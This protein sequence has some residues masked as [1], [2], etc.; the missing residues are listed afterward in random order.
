ILVGGISGFGV[1]GGAHRLW[2]H[3]SY[4]AKLPLRIILI[5]SFSASGQNPLFDWVRDHRVHHKYSETDADPHNAN[6]GFFF[7][8]VGWLMMKKHPEVIR[9][10]KMIFMEDILSDPVVIFHQKYFWPM[11]MILC[12]ILPT[13]I[14]I[15]LWNESWTNSILSMCFVRVCCGLNFTWLVN[16]AAHIWGNRPYDKRIMPAENPTVSFLAMG[17]GWHNYHHVFPWDYKAGELGNYSGYTLNITTLLIDLF[18][19][20]GWAYDMKSPD[21]EFIRKILLRSKLHPAKDILAPVAHYL[22]TKT[23]SIN[24]KILKNNVQCVWSVSEAVQPSKR[25]PHSKFPNRSKSHHLPYRPAS[26]SNN[27]NSTSDTTAS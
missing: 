18:S 15:F 20:I 21:T 8:H 19:L 12:F 9:R 24:P 14:P 26:C 27:P 6:R 10:G 23:E 5:M 25:R 16:S 2:T 7:A 17:E 3:R 1:T 13:L 4:K 11:K 22:G